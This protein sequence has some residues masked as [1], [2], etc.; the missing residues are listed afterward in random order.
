ML[1]LVL[2]SHL[3]FS[4]DVLRGPCKSDVMRFCKDVKPGSG[5]VLRCLRR[6]TDRL[7]SD[8]KAHRESKSAEI[9]QRMLACQL[10][11]EKLCKD[12]KPGRGRIHK[13]LKR[14]ED[15]L[16]PACLSEVEKVK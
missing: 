4:T 9:R 16:S 14:H 8:C 11:V 3:A 5:R 7:S 10:D 2:I 12:L 13:C 6:N 15:E 1:L